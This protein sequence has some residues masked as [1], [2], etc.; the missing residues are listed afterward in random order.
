VCEYAEY[1]RYVDTC[2]VR[3]SGLW[4]YLVNRYSARKQKTRDRNSNKPH[5]DN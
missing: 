4:S 3:T 5:L 1:K 2:N